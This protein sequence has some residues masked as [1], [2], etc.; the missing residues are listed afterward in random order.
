[1]FTIAIVSIGVA[2]LGYFIATPFILSNKL[3]SINRILRDKQVSSIEQD[4]PEWLDKPLNAFYVNTSHNTYLPSFQN[5]SFATYD[6]I[7][8]ALNE[9]ARCIELDIHYKDQ[10]LYVG[11][12]NESID[13]TSKL[14]PAKCFETINNYGFNTSD[15]LILYLEIVF[16]DKRGRDQLIAILKDKFKDRLLDPMYRLD[17]DN[18]VLVSKERIGNLLNKVIIIVSNNNDGFESIANDNGNWF[19]NVQEGVP[20][21]K[22]EGAIVRIYPKPGIGQNFSINFDPE[23]FWQQGAGIV[24]MNFQ[25]KDSG[26]LKNVLKFK[27]SNFVP[28]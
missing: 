9:G 7:K 13:T 17:A 2:M 10:L 20:F 21:K 16:N 22:P 11:H 23:P 26:L 24:G 8:N 25:T 6:S 19:K 5:V 1:M 3:I 12:G 4:H 18:R 27:D 14:D 28:M 15:P